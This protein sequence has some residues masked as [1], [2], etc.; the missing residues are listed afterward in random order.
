MYMHAILDGPVI[1]AISNGAVNNT[2]DIMWTYII[3]AILHGAVID[4]ILNG[5]VIKAILNEPAIDVILN[6]PA[7]DVISNYM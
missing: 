7:I 2:C 6:G 4:A 3:Y 1:D 5:H